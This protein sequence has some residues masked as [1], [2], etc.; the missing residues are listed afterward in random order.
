MVEK[1]EQ[2]CKYTEEAPGTSFV[3][4]LQHSPTTIA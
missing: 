2:E 3:G 4:K 1:W